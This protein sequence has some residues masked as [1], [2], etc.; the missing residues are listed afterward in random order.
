MDGPKYSKI[1]TLFNRGETFAVDTAEL[2]RPE[3]AMVDK[4]LVTEKLDGTNVR[5]R[6]ETGLNGMGGQVI[7]GGRTDKAQLQ[8]ELLEYLQRTFTVSKLRGVLGDG[9]YTLFGEGIGG[10]IQKAGPHY[11]ELA[12]VLFDVRLD[13]GLLLEL[14][15]VYSIAEGLG[16]TAVPTIDSCMATAKIVQLVRDGLRNQTE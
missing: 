15:N 6:W 5:V 7:F 10:R 16:V 4:W 11:G 3:F 8:T 9:P 2:R 12:F 1:E 13:D 14:N